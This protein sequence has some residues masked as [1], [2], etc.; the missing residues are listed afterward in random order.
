MAGEGVVFE[1]NMAEKLARAAEAKRGKLSDENLR[2]MLDEMSDGQFSKKY[3]AERQQQLVD[4]MNYVLG[5]VYEAK[6]MN[7][8]SELN[9]L[10]NRLRSE[11]NKASV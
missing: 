1:S 2:K 7:A 5:A 4:T 9:N 10:V 8:I 3:S 11:L 6:D